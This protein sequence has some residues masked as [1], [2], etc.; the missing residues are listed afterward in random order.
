MEYSKYSGNITGV[1]MN[2][3]DRMNIAVQKITKKIKI[4]NKSEKKRTQQK[5]CI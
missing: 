4:K 3:K 5:M 1:M 2:K